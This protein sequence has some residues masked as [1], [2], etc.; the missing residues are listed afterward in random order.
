M[1]QSRIHPD[2]A[3]FMKQKSLPDFLAETHNRSRH[4]LILYY[5]AKREA[6]AC[7]TQAGGRSVEFAGPYPITDREFNTLN[8]FQE[9]LAVAR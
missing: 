3:L 4:Y 8:A 2:L 6:F 7:R 5:L 9:N 1:A